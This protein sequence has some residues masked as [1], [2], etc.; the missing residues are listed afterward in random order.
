[1]PGQKTQPRWQDGRRS[2][3][4]I[5]V[6]WAAA[7][8]GPQGRVRPR[9]WL[10]KSEPAGAWETERQSGRGITPGQ[11]HSETF[12]VAQLGGQ[13]PDLGVAGVWVRILPVH[14][15]PLTFRFRFPAAV[16]HATPKRSGFKLPRP[17]VSQ[18][19]VSRPGSAE[20]FSGPTRCRLG[21]GP[22]RRLEVP[23]ALLP[24]TPLPRTSPRSSG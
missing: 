11:R 22:P 9:R 4:A 1:M 12:V 7:E 24:E 16:S 21:C 14:R 8:P 19:S 15:L 5:R 13:K 10:T 17:L 6:S 18:R 20:R 23:P 2:S 3:C